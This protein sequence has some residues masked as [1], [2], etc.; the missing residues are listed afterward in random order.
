MM[1][2][3]P[4][5]ASPTSK[6]RRGQTAIVMACRRASAL[7]RGT[8]LA[9]CSD[10]LHL[11]L[12][13]DGTDDGSLS[14][15]KS[16]CEAAPG[17]IHLVHLPRSQ[18]L[19][20]ALRQGMLAATALPYET[21][22]VWDV[23][24]GIPAHHIKQFVAHMERQPELIG[25]RGARVGRW[26]RGLLSRPRHYLA[27]RTIATAAAQLLRMPLVDTQALAQVYRHDDALKEAIAAPF[28]A[29]ALFDV[30]LLAQLALAHRK[31]GVDITDK[32]A[33]IPLPQWHHTY[34]PRY[35]PVEM[36]RATADL[37]KL[38]HRRHHWKDEGAS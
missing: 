33:S 36:I 28:P 9:T 34:K 31:R 29:S 30:T 21:I 22:G 18:G 7:R 5:T 17:Q 24:L 32:L 38:A 20:E 3:E 8:L 12:V 25:V 1:S 15:I 13:D 35:A 19:A 14:Q 26:R 10:E 2:V 6:V 16:L 23:A 11:W 4:T 37:L 27:E